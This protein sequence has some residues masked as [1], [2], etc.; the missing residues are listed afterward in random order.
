MNIIMGFN[1]GK[2]EDVQ[3]FQYHFANDWIFLK[4]EK[5]GR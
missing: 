3:A 5:M 2:L 4:E 1:L